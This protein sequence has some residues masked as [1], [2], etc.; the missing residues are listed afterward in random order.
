MVTEKETKKE[1]EICSPLYEQEHSV[2]SPN[3]N[4]IDNGRQLLLHVRCVMK[5][6]IH[7]TTNHTI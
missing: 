7:M 5:Y 4:L 3:L 6:E 2:P 1:S